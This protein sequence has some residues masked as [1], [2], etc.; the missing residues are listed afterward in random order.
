VLCQLTHGGA[1]VYAGTNP[2]LMPHLRVAGG[3]TVFGQY[4]AASA[5]HAARF[6]PL[7]YVSAQKVAQA[8]EDPD[9]FVWDGTTESGGGA[10][11]FGVRASL[12]EHRTRLVRAGGSAAHVPVEHAG[13]TLTTGGCQLYSFDVQRFAELGFVHPPAE[14][15]AS[16]SS[17]GGSIAAG[18]YSYAFTFEHYDAS[19]ARHQSAPRFYPSTITHASGSTNKVTF[20]LY[21][22][23]TTRKQEIDATGNLP[24]NTVIAVWRTTLA[25]PGIFY[26]VGTA[27]N[28]PE[29]GTTHSFEDTFADATIATH[30]VLYTTSGELANECPP[31][32]RHA[33]LFAGRVAGIDAEWED[34]IVFSKPIRTGAGPSFSSILETWVRGIGRLTALAEMDGSL[35][36]FSATAVALAAYGEGQDALGAGQWPTPQVITRAAGCVDPRALCVTQDGIIYCSK[37]N[38]PLRIWLMPRGGG[39]PVEI[40]SKVRLYLDGAAPLFAPGTTPTVTSCVNWAAES[41]V[42]I[43]LLASSGASCVLEYDYRTRGEDGLGSWNATIGGPTDFGVTSMV[44]AGGDLWVGIAGNGAETYVYKST[45]GTYADLDKTG[46][47]EEWIAYRLATHDFKLG[48]LAPMVKVNAVNFTM[49]EIG[50]N[51][52]VALGITQDSFATTVSAN[53]DYASASGSLSQKFWQPPIRRSAEAKGFALSLVSSRL[54]GGQSANSQ[55]VLP[56]SVTI[57]Y[58]PFGTMHRPTTAERI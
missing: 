8:V 12:H 37:H 34:R 48:S 58:V 32:M 28:N 19:G 51:A 39:N 22:L 50:G 57:D 42:E 53:A 54:D 1:L 40:G 3:S 13:L 31:P 44:V 43:S 23:R 46:G 10:E 11:G 45:S 52:R 18:S 33:V 9:L 47:T 21:P 4:A 17:S 36:A 15:A 25:A 5:G 16:S 56:R 27:Q 30:E 41:R 29:Q 24:A 7:S 35:F 26:R 14:P 20:S 2:G 55:D 38:G 6:N 49:Q